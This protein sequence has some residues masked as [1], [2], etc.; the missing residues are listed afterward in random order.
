M[1]NPTTPASYFHALR[2]QIH[3]DFRKPLIVMAPKSLLR[4]KRAVS[5]FDDLTGTRTFHRVLWDDH[6]E[7]AADAR[8]RRVVICSGKVYY[9]LLEAKEQQGIHDVYVLRL[10]QLYPFPDDALAEELK[11]FPGAEVLWCQE[12]PQNCGAW[13]FVLPRLA[14]VL[15]VLG[16]R[17][18]PP[19]YVGRS[20]MAAPAPGSLR[21]HQ[22]QQQQLVNR[23][24]A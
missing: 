19:A 24:L 8:I 18:G 9:D 16:P 10:E 12:E 1:V 5:T 7:V 3:R 20:E 2:R 15:N 11:R 21:L 4:H 13:Q 14:S 17:S 6:R 22:E 23:A